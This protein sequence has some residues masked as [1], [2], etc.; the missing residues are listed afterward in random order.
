M[1]ARAA[2]SIW[3]RMRASSGETITDGPAPRER[4]SAVAVKYTADL[5]QPVRCTTSARRCSATR[6]WIAVHWSSRSRASGPARACRQRSASARSGLGSSSAMLSLL[7]GNADRF[8]QPAHAEAGQILLLTKIIF[9]EAVAARPSY[10]PLFPAPLF[11]A[12]PGRLPGSGCGS[13][14]DLARMVADLPELSV[15]PV[16]IEQDIERGDSTGR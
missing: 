14:V 1:P 6:A 2:A 12:P 4:S 5:P 13:C 8:S 3:L 10:A 15:P 11:P 7:S 9:E 16:S